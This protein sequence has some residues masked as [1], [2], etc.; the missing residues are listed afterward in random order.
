MGLAIQP[1]GLALEMQKA[2]LFRL[3]GGFERGKISGRIG[4]RSD[5][6]GRQSTGKPG[7]ECARK[8]LRSCRQD[9]ECHSVAYD[10]PSIPEKSNRKSVAFYL[11]WANG[12]IPE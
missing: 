10:L 4:S 3:A 7:S 6:H 5:S 8:E 2:S 1:G 12:P 9:S 11:Q